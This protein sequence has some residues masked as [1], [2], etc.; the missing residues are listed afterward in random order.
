MT[1]IKV[2]IPEDLKVEMDK[3]HYI[4]WSKV[5]RD[6]IRKKITELSVL[7]SIAQK[8]E[9]TEEDAIELGRDI[10]RGIHK[11]YKESYPDME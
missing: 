11:R 7:N 9:L 1:E 6:S 5:A 2:K 8:S 3:L 10:N 4:D